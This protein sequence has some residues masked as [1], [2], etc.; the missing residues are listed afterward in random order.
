MALNPTFCWELPLGGPPGFG[1]PGIELDL[2][3]WVTSDHSQILSVPKFLFGTIKKTKT[4]KIVSFLFILPL[5]REG[6]VGE[7]ASGQLC[8]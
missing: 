1:F 4:K 3:R 6:R 5:A 2:I 7:E 8:Y